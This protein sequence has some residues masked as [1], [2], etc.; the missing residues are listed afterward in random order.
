[1]TTPPHANSVEDLEPIL[2]PPGLEIKTTATARRNNPISHKGH[3]AAF[4]SVV[5]TLQ[6]RHEKLGSALCPAHLG[7]P[8]CSPKGPTP[9][10]RTRLYLS[11]QLGCTPSRKQLLTSWSPALSHRAPA[12]LP[13]HASSLLPPARKNMASGRWSSV[14]PQVGGHT[15]SVL[16][17]LQSRGLG[18]RAESHSSH[19]QGSQ[20]LPRDYHLSSRP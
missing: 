9:N 13:H 5:S 16:A 15:L 7:D 3:I 12:S 19:S 2:R 1:M 17:S 6:G 10:F 11:H 20:P 14:T 8:G 18:L 4:L